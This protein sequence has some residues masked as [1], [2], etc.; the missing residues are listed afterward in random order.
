[1]A[2]C[3]Q[4]DG[5]QVA[6]QRQKVGDRKR[7]SRF[8]K[9][10][11]AEERKKAEEKKNTWESYKSPQSYGKAIRKAEKAFPSSPRESRLCFLG[12]P[13]VLEK[14]WLIRLKGMLYLKKLKLL[15]KIS[16]NVWT[17]YIPYLYIYQS[18]DQDYGDLGKWEKVYR[19]KT[20]PSD[21]P[22]RSICC[23][24][25]HLPRHCW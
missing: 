8:I 15:L 9:Q 4:A 6:Q 13:N 3:Q 10:I 23:V 2:D 21:V 12:W 1:M 5:Q 7:K 16:T 24:Q 14:V 11:K 18:R 22:E 25:K 17:L 20:L 19:T